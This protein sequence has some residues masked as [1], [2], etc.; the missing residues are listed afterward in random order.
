MINYEFQADPEKYLNEIE[1]QLKKHKQLQ[2]NLLRF[3]QK[4]FENNE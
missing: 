2:G 1:N 4:E 3:T